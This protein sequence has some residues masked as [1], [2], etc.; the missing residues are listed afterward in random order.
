MRQPGLKPGSFRCDAALKGRS[1]TLRREGTYIDGAR[2]F[3]LCET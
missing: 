1:P 3:T 2:R